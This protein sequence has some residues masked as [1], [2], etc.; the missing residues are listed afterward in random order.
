MGRSSRRVSRNTIS[1]IILLLVG[2]F[3][4]IPFYIIVIMSF[5]H[6]NDWTPKFLPPTYLFFGNFIDA[7]NQGQL[8]QAFK[9]NFIVTFISIILILAV[10]SICAYPL[11]RYKTRLNRII[12]NG[13][14]ACLIVPGLTIMVPL[15][16]IMASLHATSSYLAVIVVHVTFAMPFVVF[17]YS[18]FIGT[19]PKELDEAAMI[20]GLSRMG[21]CFRIVLPLLVP[22]TITII[23][24][25]GIGI[26]NDYQM[27]LFFLQRPDLYTLTVQIA[28]FFGTYR[29]NTYM[30]AAGCLI[31]VLP[32][33]TLFIFLQRYF[34]KG[35]SSGAL[36]L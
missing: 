34:I 1:K 9:N 13:I 12:Y 25:M 29:D 3:Y 10:G 28:M 18:G 17:L 6:Q 7:W 2:L 8:G 15:Y 36:K 4:L 24:I 23:I 31:A 30:V 26:W 14:I 22:I 16:S 35:L 20:D 21:V 5:K 11:S 27:S 19:I 33:I 32:M